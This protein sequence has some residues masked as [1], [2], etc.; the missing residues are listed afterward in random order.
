MALSFTN[1]YGQ[2]DITMITPDQISELTPEQQQALS[3]LIDA[4]KARETAQD[5]ELAAVKRV[6]AT[7]AAEDQ[8]QAAHILANPPPSPQEAQRAAINAFNGV[9]D[10]D[11]ETGKPKSHPKHAKA[12]PRIAWQR[13]Q[14]ATEDARIELNAATSQARQMELI[15]SDALSHWLSLQRQPT[16]D[17]VFRAKIAAEQA[18]RLERVSAGLSPEPP[19]KPTHNRSPIDTLAAQRPRQTAQMPSSPL[20]SPVARRSV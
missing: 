13:A 9:V 15:E 3:I 19:K 17:E 18:A 20:R 12:G 14:A 10:T 6:N 8:A 1:K 2:L 11:D 4:V 5:R 7:Q 16:Q